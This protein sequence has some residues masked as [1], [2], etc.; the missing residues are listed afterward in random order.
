MIEIPTPPV[1]PAP[2]LPRLYRRCWASAPCS[3]VGLRGQLLS[4]RQDPRQLWARWTYSSCVAI[5][6]YFG[7]SPCSNMRKA[8][9]ASPRS[10]LTC[11]LMA[12][13]SSGGPDR[14]ALDVHCLEVTL[15]KALF[16]LEK[17]FSCSHCRP[18]G[19][20]RVNC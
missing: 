18:R 6:W 19:R 14:S 17:R 13:P 9:G 4:I 15:V 8:S 1:P 12:F 3:R 10:S 16:R 5:A 11:S 2:L 20:E 7:A